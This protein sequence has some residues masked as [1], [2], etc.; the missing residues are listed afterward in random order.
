MTEFEVL[1][2]TATVWQWLAEHP[3]ATKEEAY[4]A[5]NSPLD[6]NLCSLCTHAVDYCPDCLL[7]GL[8]PDGCCH[9]GS[10]YYVW[11]NSEDPDERT[12]AAWVI[13]NYTFH[14]IEELQIALENNST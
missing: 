5:L 10:P 11:S 3:G 9:R 13:T 1:K 12:R 14:L 2:K 4:R 8:W 6:R 7:R